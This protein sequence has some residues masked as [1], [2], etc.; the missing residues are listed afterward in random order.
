MT[1]RM[2]RL[3]GGVIILIWLGILLFL[4][5]LL[6]QRQVR[7]MLL[8]LLIVQQVVLLIIM[9]VGGFLMGVMITMPMLMGPV[10]FI[11][12]RLTGLMLMM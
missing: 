11:I 4:V 1:R 10:H 2:V 12:C 6:R 9:L 8:R 7:H 5:G 3:L